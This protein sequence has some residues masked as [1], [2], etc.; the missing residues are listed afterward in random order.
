MRPR[1]RFGA[2]APKLLSALLGHPRLLTGPQSSPSN[3]SLLLHKYNRPTLRVVLVIFA[4]GER[5][6]LSVPFGTHAFQACALDHYA[7]PPMRQ[8]Y[9]LQGFLL[10][11]TGGREIAAASFS[12]LVRQGGASLIRGFRST[13]HGLN[14]NARIVAPWSSVT[15]V[16]LSPVF[17]SR[18]HDC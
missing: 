13:A 17:G 8:E 3:L 2:V 15:H 10:K 4:E 7:N 6:E 9:T 16:H 12:I 11:E 1:A 5:F 18:S 14:G